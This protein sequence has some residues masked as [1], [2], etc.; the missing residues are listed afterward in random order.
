MFNLSVP[1]YIKKYTGTAAFGNFKITTSYTA[2]FSDTNNKD[3]YIIPPNQVTRAEILLRNP[4]LTITP[5]VEIKES[6][7]WVR[8]YGAGDSCSFLYGTVR[9]LAKYERPGRII[10]TIGNETNPA[11]HPK[12]GD[13]F[14]LRVLIQLNDGTQRLDEK[15]TIV[16]PVIKCNKKPAAPSI[17]RVKLSPDGLGLNLH[18]TLPGNDAADPSGANRLNISCD[19]WPGEEVY[20]RSLVDSGGGIMV[21]D[22]WQPS[23]LNSI[24]GSMPYIHEAFPS[25]AVSMTA[26]YTVTL[27]YSNDDLYTEAQGIYDGN[28]T[29]FYVS[30]FGGG[31]GANEISPTTFNDAVTRIISDD[32][33]KAVIILNESIDLTSQ[34][35]TGDRTL[36]VTSRASAVITQTAPGD[37]LTVSAGAA[38]ILDGSMDGIGNV[39]YQG[40]PNNLGSLIVV[41][42]GGTLEMNNNVI[43]GGNYLNNASS[44]RGGAAVCLDGSSAKFTMNGGTIT[45][46]FIDSSHSIQDGAGVWVNNGTFEMR[47]GTITGNT[48]S[49]SASPSRGGGV[50]VQGTTGSFVLDGGTIRSNAAKAGGGVHV[51][52]GASF[53]MLSGSIINNNTAYINYGGGVYVS[54][55]QSSFVLKGGNIGGNTASVR[56]GGIY[57][58]SGTL[59]IEGSNI[60]GNASP[61]GGGV[62]VVASGLAIMSG[63]H[64]YDNNDIGIITFGGG[65]Y[66]SGPSA[67]FTLSGG[68]INGNKAA[69]SGGGVYVE[70]GGTFA[71]SSGSIINSMAYRGAGVFAQDNGTKIEIAGGTIRENYCPNIGAGVSINGGA[72]ATMTGGNIIDNESGNYGGGVYIISSEFI[73]KG[74]TIGTAGEG[75]VAALLGGGVFVGGNGQFIMEESN[76]NIPMVQYNAVNSSGKG[77]GVYIEA[78]SGTFTMKGGIIQRN[79]KH[80]VCVEGSSSSVLGK[81]YMSG[82]SMV[83]E[84]N[85]VYLALDSALHTYSACIFVGD[86]IGAQD[87]AA[88]IEY[89]GN[90]TMTVLKPDPAASPGVVA[91]SLTKFRVSNSAYK[92]SPAGG[93]TAVIELK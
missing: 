79:G 15:D 88:V 58:D 13:E 10:L 17:N 86:G 39:S 18:W 41:E 8:Y 28:I 66:V 77:G 33:K 49:N 84:D 54:G 52:D 70:R 46:N 64:M 81:F 93:D 27:R 47:G 34:H 89:N 38:L 63:G 48:V 55:T 59:R 76:G 1:E 57:T 69:N 9:I 16:L 30:N 37:L 85:T 19:Q 23:G 45:G 24:S 7:V 92:L 71:M 20:T 73:M 82:N 65:I 25:R 60:Y 6:G 90:E 3:Q 78:S 67:S 80:G 61:T 87:Y 62:C 40:L 35:I 4:G 29:F 72:R 43:L 2:P 53:T 21:W 32:I 56:G 42:N 44:S 51:N 68:K 31:T 26:T 74:G 91:A 5:V 12:A 11:E 75:N 14:S 36:T 50:Y 83:T 22:S